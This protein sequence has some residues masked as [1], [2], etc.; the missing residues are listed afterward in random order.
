MIDYKE[1]SRQRDIA[2]KRIKRMQEAG[3]K[4]KVHIPTVKELRADPG[5]ASTEFSNLSKFLSGSNSLS[6][7]R[8][9]NRP[10][11]PE[12]KREARREYERMRRRVK[13]TEAF[14]QEVGTKTD[15]KRF[16]KGIKKLGFDF[17]PSQLPAFY[18]YMEYRFAQGTSSYK[19]AFA[20]FVEEYD[21]MLRKGYKPEHIIDDY[22][23][24]VADQEATKRKSRRMKGTDNKTAKKYWS[25]F[26]G[27]EV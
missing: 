25:Q 11:T 14:Q 20:T 4:I 7:K 6:A 21:A 17:K 24:F 27:W 16:I 2:Q 23:Q 15:Y 22:Q 18:K 10:K 26:G 3:Y 5:R 13:V 19:Y 9:A 1:Y 12:A 8:E